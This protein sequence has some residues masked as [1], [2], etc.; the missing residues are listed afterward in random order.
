MPGEGEDRPRVCAD[1]RRPGALDRAAPGL[2]AGASFYTPAR[3]CFTA[4][5]AQEMFPQT[6]PL[7]HLEG[8]CPRC[9][10]CSLEAA[11]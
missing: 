8:Q 6:S 4:K 10:P 2:W 9:H 7:G 5:W 3:G 11:I 1:E